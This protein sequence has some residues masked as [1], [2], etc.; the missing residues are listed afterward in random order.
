MG[1]TCKLG[2]AATWDQGGLGQSGE[3]ESFIGPTH[4]TGSQEMSD[5]TPHAIKKLLTVGEVRIYWD[6]VMVM[7]PNTGQIEDRDTICAAAQNCSKLKRASFRPV[8]WRKPAAGPSS[9]GTGPAKSLVLIC[10]RARS[11]KWMVMRW[12][13]AEVSL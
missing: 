11:T 4:D 13:L 1:L 3:K 12:S 10:H 5:R 6:P 2:L 7:V 9:R 8:M